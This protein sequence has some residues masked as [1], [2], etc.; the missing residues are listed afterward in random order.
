[1]N[2]AHKSP[3]FLILILSAVLALALLSCQ[4]GDDTPI[5]TGP[6]TD[7]V[8]SSDGNNIVYDV[9]G[10]SERALVFVHCWC[11][12]R[13]YW[14]AQVERFSAQ[15]RVVTIDLAGHGESGD[16]REAWT[17]ELF[18]EDVA[19]VV[20]DLGLKDVILVG[21]SMGGRVCIEAALR[22]PGIVKAIVGVDNFHALSAMPTAS[23]IDN[24]IDP[25]R[26]DFPE[27]T[28][29]FVHSL[30]PSTAD[31]ALVE[32]V[33]TDM[34][35]APPEVGIG[36]MEQ[37]YGYDRAEALQEMRLPLRS[38]NSDAFKVDVDGNREVAES[39][40][41][42]TMSGVGHFLHME[43]PDDF[44]DLLNRTIMEFWPDQQRE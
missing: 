23:D 4:S 38:I 28:N 7:S 20:T 6:F 33:A 30:F 42:V 5:A 34:A 15:Y 19:A 18:G 31:T 39:Y 27:F 44:N 14:D 35:A 13:G 2:N 1:M 21:H 8:A 10:T 40:S 16:N 29:Q 9:H 25:M 43:S 22:L 37:I 32:R 3:R 12:D 36:A 24:F 26:E 11:C 41:V 17:M